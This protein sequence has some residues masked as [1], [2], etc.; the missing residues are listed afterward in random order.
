MVKQKYDR[1][2]NFSAGPSVLPLE[3]LEKFLKS[4]LSDPH[5]T[6][7]GWNYNYDLH[8]MACDGIPIAPNFEDA[9]LALHLLNENEPNF[10]LK[11]AAERYGIG[12]GSLQESILEYVKCSDSI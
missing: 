3:V 12:T 6:Y 5:R 7:G 4:Y 10:K 1:V 9:M 11:D 8:M 2:Y